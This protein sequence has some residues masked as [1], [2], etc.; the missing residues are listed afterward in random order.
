MST[1]TSAQKKYL[2]G[3]AHEL[4]P[5]VLVGKRG[6]SEDLINEIRDALKAHELIKIKF[7][8]HKEERRELAR[9]IEEQATCSIVGE[10]GNMAILYRQHPNKEKR[11]I[12]LPL[13]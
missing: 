6:V 5:V 1:L 4:Q 12:T 2:R 8:E 10:I 9:E 7:I 11:Q 3:L 13:F